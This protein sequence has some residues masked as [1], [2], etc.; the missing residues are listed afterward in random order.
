MDLGGGGGLSLWFL[1]GEWER[2]RGLTFQKPFSMPKACGE[3]GSWSASSSACAWEN[4]CCCSCCIVVASSSTE[5]AGGAAVGSGSGLGAAADDVVVPPGI[6]IIRAMVSGLVS[7]GTLC[8]HRVL[9]SG[10]NFVDCWF[11]SLRAAVCSGH[12]VSRSDVA[13]NK[14]YGGRWRDPVPCAALSGI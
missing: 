4:G 7:K 6:G 5:N 12:D 14:W 13:W 9:G 1:L 10:W 2:G 3:S 11:K 8:R